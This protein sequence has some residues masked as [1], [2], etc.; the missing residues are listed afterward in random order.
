MKSALKITS[1]L[2]IAIFVGNCSTWSLQASY[3]VSLAQIDLSSALKI[4][5]G[6]STKAEV[7]SLFGSPDATE[8]QNGQE[9]WTYYLPKTESQRPTVTFG[10]RTSVVES[11]LWVPK[12]ASE[13]KLPTIQAI[14]PHAKFQT[15][16]SEQKQHFIVSDLT[17]VDQERKI[18]ILSRKSSDQADAV[19]WRA[20]ES[21]LPSAEE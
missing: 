12:D 8:I 5:A 11:V 17:Y 2:I 18:S 20:P 15:I 10:K 16:E 9:E 4:Q 19:A 13:G 14:F 3:P 1:I 21:R 6:K 7:E